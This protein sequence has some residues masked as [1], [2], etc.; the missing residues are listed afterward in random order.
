MFGVVFFARI[1]RINVEAEIAARQNLDLVRI[2]QAI[3]SLPELSCTIGNVQID[4]CYDILKIEAFMKILEDNP[5]YFQGTLLY[6][7]TINIRQ[8]DPFNDVWTNEW[9]LHD[10]NIENSDQRKI[11]VPVLLYDKRTATKHFGVL[12]LTW[13]ILR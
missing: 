4:N 12:D 9:N 1:H 8:Y 11:F 7:T 2:S 6:Y 5:G 3:S 10:N 13:Y